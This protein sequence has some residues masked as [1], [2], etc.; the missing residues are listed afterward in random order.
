MG[1][2]K[3][4]G[5]YG[6][7]SPGSN[8]VRHSEESGF[9]LV[10]IMAVMIILAV[11]AAVAIPKIASSSD[12]ARKNADIA[13]GHEVKTALDR[14]QVENGIYPKTNEITASEGTLTA[15]GLIPKYISKLDTSTTQQRA[16]DDKKGFGVATLPSDGVTYPTATNLI[17][18]YL[19]SDGSSAEVRTYDDQGHVL[20]TSAK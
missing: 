16:A 3:G 6:V 5:K 1:S 4:I 15:S 18:I 12:V 13:T 14:Y 11:L 2:F 10:E 20:W 17:V 7:I 8:R 19:T 9:T